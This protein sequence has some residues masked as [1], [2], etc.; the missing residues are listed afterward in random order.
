MAGRP[1][2]TRGVAGGGAPGRVDERDALWRS[3]CRVAHLVR[4]DD[5]EAAMEEVPQARRDVHHAFKA[6]GRVRKSGEGKRR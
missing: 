2:S 4:V 6:A 3:P 1:F 5:G